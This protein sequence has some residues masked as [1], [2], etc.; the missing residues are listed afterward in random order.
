MQTETYNTIFLVILSAIFYSIP[1]IWINKVKLNGATACISSFF[2]LITILIYA[3]LIKGHSISEIDN[4]SFKK[5]II[6]GIFY[7]LGLLFY[8]EAI[9]YNQPTLLNLQTI[10]IF[11]LSTLIAFMVLNEISNVWKIFGITTVI[12][13]TALIVCG[14]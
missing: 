3:F 2:V 11:I 1:L 14:Q 12:V 4:D 9:K 7:G 6:S 5:M 8:I 10:F 13:G